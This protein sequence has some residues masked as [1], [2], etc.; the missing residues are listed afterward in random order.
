MVVSLLH[1][2]QLAGRKLRR[3]A[4]YA[5]DADQHGHVRYARAS[6]LRAGA[7][8]SSRVR[9][10]DCMWECGCAR[11]YPWE[12]SGTWVIL[13]YAKGDRKYDVDRNMFIFFIIMSVRS[14]VP[15][16]MWAG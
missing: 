6:E 10:C 9:S 5:V 3:I 11:G 1:G 12:P 4:T 2:D 14:L 13:I 16:Q 8:A 15:A 7:C